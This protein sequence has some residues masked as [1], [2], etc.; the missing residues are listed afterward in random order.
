MVTPV[1]YRTTETADRPKD[2]LDMPVTL[3]EF[4]EIAARA[5]MPLKR[6]AGDPDICIVCVNA[7]R[8]IVT[9]DEFTPDVSA[10][11]KEAANACA[12]ASKD[13]KRLLKLVDQI[14]KFHGQI[15]WSV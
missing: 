4:E 14:V 10:R 6:E 12:A 8:E 1:E 5:A 15:H 3:S 13:R 2:L 9:P 7:N 11:F